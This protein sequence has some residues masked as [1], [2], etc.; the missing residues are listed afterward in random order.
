MG[1]RSSNYPTGAA[2][3]SDPGGRQVRP[4][5]TSDWPAIC[6]VGRKLMS[7]SAQASLEIMGSMSQ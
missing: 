3:A 6:A 5:Y 7:R 4:E 1:R 2:L